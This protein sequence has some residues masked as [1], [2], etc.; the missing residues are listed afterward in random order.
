MNQASIRHDN[1][2]ESA[3]GNANDATA[4][5]EVARRRAKEACSVVAEKDDFKAC[6][7]GNCRAGKRLFESTAPKG[8]HLAPVPNNLSILEET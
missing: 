3:P 8:A 7:F 6:G 5:V 4:D 1:R 2:P